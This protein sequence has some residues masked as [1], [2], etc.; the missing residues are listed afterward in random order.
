MTAR[1]WLGGRGNQAS[2]PLDWSP[3]GVLQPGDTLTITQGSINISGSQIG[4]DVLDASGSTRVN[5]KNGINDHLTVHDGARV[6][7]TNTFG[8][9]IT[10]AQGD[11]SLTTTGVNQVDIQ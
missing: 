10:K 5:I 11:V 7:L 6:Y 1:T 3:S 2:D 8:A 9:K 4:V